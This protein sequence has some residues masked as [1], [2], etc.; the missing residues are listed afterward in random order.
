MVS[1]N[2]MITF[3]VLSL[4]W[5]IFAYYGGS[6]IPDQQLWFALLTTFFIRNAIVYGGNLFDNHPENTSRQSVP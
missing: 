5:L 3:W 4:G 1:L 6:M 2:R